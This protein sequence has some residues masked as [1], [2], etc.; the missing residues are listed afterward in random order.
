MW[1]NR[2]LPMKSDALENTIECG[3]RFKFIVILALVTVASLVDVAVNNTERLLW[4]V[5]S[6]GCIKSIIG[7]V[8]GLVNAESPNN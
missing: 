4:M 1:L 5:L 8:V 3:C 2:S 6:V 7:A